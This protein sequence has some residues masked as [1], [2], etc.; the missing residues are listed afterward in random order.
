MLSNASTKMMMKNWITLKPTFYSH[1]KIYP[2]LLFNCSNGNAKV[3]T[4]FAQHA[5]H[6]CSWVCVCVYVLVGV[7]VL[8]CVCVC[9][10]VSFCLYLLKNVTHQQTML[11]SS[12]LFSPLIKVNVFSFKSWY[13]HVWRVWKV[14]ARRLSTS[15]ENKNPQVHLL[16]LECLFQ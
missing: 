1:T 9:L 14:T 3:S 11:V 8:V 12:L 13:S 5:V 7:F 6:I 2:H 4:T 15:Y 10:K 16:E